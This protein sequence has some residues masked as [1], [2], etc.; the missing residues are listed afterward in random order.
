MAECRRYR[1]VGPAEVRDRTAVDV[2]AVDGS[3]SLDG[4][5]AGRGGGELA[6]P[7]TFVVDLDGVLRL[8]P[9]RSEHVVLA[10]GRRVL[11]AGEMSFASTGMGW[12][13]VAVTNQWTG[14]CPDPDCWPAVASALDRVGVPHPGGFTDRVTFRCCPGCGERNIVRDEDFTCAMCGGALPAQWNFASE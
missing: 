12:R 3:A 4:W 13:V 8:A 1:Y 2:V 9:R 14:Y 6:E 10:D 5:L 7:V 11:A